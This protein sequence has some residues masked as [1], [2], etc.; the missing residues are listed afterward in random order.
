MGSSY[1]KRRH[2]QQFGGDLINMHFERHKRE[3]LYPY[4]NGPRVWTAE[5]AVRI[6]IDDNDFLHTDVLGQEMQM[7]KWGVPEQNLTKTYCIAK[8][9]DFSYYT[10]SRDVYLSCDEKR[11]FTC[12]TPKGSV[13]KKR[14]REIRIRK[15][16]RI[17]HTNADRDTQK[18]LLAYPRFIEIFL[19]EILNFFRN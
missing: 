2:C 5:T 7:F 14:I 18:C 15:I 6:E 9:R 12:E 19:S 16:R 10:N 13:S 17:P 1:K 4:D 11:T 8:S 3:L